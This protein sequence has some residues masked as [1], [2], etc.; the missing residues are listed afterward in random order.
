MRRLAFLTGTR[1]DYGKIKPL[2]KAIQHT[3]LFKI[4][5]LV[6]GMH[7][8][9]Q[10]G[11][12]VGQ[13]IEDAL[14]EVHFL[15]NQV[16]EQAME[17]SLAKTIEQLSSFVSEHQIDLLIVHGDRIEALA[18]AIV[19]ALRNI[20]TAHIEGGEV[21][22]TVDGLIRHSVSK[23]CHVHF[24]SNEEAEN[25]LIQLGENPSS[26]FV[27]GSPDI[28]VM[29][30][31]GL[32][33]KLE[34]ME[35]YEIPFENYSILIFHPVTTE[36][37]KIEEQ[38]LEVVHAIKNDTQNYIVIKPNNDNG[39]ETIQRYLSQ[40]NGTRFIHLPS[41]R[42]EYFLTL[43][44]ESR[45]IIGNS[46]AGVREAPYF[47]VPTVNIGSRQ[48]NRAAGPQIFNVA[49]V[50]GQ[51]AQGIESALK[52]TRARVYKFGR[53]NAADKFVEILT[54]NEIWLIGTDKI[55]IDVEK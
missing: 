28:D 9:P 32:P 49:P 53:G 54:S 36:V 11:S 14:G 51:I 40:L 43:L 4:D 31:D 1:A 37:E 27:I 47:G 3:G 2:M 39:S 16:S 10:Y 20:P 35:R 21:S 22:G 41:M 44:K 17:I 33:S 12:T 38:I 5:I 50:S 24:V 29:L 55:F 19:G 15:P 18:G 45:A 52:S 34:V 6:T 30:G 25:R 7:L 13:V 42:F 26:I 8:L 48:Q 23:L 46:S